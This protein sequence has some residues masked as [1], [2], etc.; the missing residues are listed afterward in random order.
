MNVFT[1]RYFIPSSSTSSSSSPYHHH[2]TIIFCTRCMFLTLKITRQQT[3][4]VESQTIHNTHTQIDTIDIFGVM[5]IYEIHFIAQRIDCTHVQDYASKQFAVHTIPCYVFKN[6]HPNESARIYRIL[7]WRVGECYDELWKWQINKV[8]V[9]VEH[10]DIGC[11]PF[12]QWNLHN[13]IT[14]YTTTHLHIAYE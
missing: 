11:M 9:Y 7:L 14:H 5:L 2:A 8:Y 13:P 4:A 1:S 3:A 6:V 12:S 10:V